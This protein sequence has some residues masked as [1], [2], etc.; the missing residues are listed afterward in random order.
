MSEFKLV[1]AKIDECLDEVSTVR[2]LVQ[3]LDNKIDWTA[4]EV[5]EISSAKTYTKLMIEGIM[6]SSASTSDNV[7]LISKDMAA[8]KRDMAAVK[9]DMAKLA[10]DMVKLVKLL[11]AT[12]PSLGAVESS[13]QS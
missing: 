6:S 12:R 1:D 4:K 2:N 5:L 7:E 13:K 8:M 9:K 3:A 11:E 10:R